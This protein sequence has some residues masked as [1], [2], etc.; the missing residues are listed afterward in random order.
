MVCLAGRTTVTLLGTK[1]YILE[2]VQ[3]NAD[4]FDRLI[5]STAVGLFAPQ[6]E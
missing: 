4:V 5:S 6:T 2:N 3:E 1:M